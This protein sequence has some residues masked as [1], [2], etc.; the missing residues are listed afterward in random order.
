VVRVCPR[1]AT[2]ALLTDA[3]GGHGGIAQY[4]RDLVSAVVGHAALGRLHILPRHAPG[5]VQALP[6]GVTQEPPIGDRARY[7][8]K[9]LAMALAIKPTL[10]FCG[11]L[12][13][14]PLG[15]ALAKAV[16]A[17]LVVQLHGVDAWA[18]PPWLRRRAVEAADLVL[19]VSH[20][21]RKRFLGW[22]RF[23]P[24][25]ALVLH[26]TVNPEFTP[27]DAAAFRSALRVQ[28]KTVL[29]SV[30]RLD[31]SER[32]KGQDRVIDMLPRLRALGHDVVYHIVG[33]GDD[34]PRLE[35]RCKELDVAQ[36]VH[37]FG[38]VPKEQLPDHYRAA[39]LFILPSSGEGFGIVFLEAMA[40]GTPALGL[41]LGGA[42]DALCNGELGVAVAE[43][44]LF[45]ATVR[46]L[47]TPSRD[48]LALSGKV[49]ERF[50]PVA[51]R[52]Q[53]NRVFSSV[54]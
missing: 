16:R 20:D 1:P 28:D 10:I 6:P 38:R 24:G 52:T 42:V 43:E 15:A 47:E 35:A 4:N 48:R 27:S 18:R 5:P 36:F 54:V 39:D 17:K 45:D 50:G 2:L 23:D 37:F 49:L 34:R 53:A 13:M 51:F 19:S 41:A 7:A 32:Y 9:A 11:H 40:C 8:A 46:A 26:N 25:R 30:S 21:T 14:A 3:Y 31:S 22:A 33:D 29:L 12:F 44:D